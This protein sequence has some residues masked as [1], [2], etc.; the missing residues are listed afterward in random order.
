V[1]T[2]S[3]RGSKRK[4][5]SSSL[6]AT[7]SLDVLFPV[8]PFATVTQPVIGVSILKAAAIAAGFSAKVKYYNLDFARTIG[9]EFSERIT[10]FFGSLSLIG[11]WLFSEALYGNETPRA[12]HYWQLLRAEY[13]KLEDEVSYGIDFGGGRT[14]SQY[15]EQDLWP[16]LLRVRR[17]AAEAVKH[18][19]ADILAQ[20]PRVVGFTTSCHQACSTLAVAQLLK[21]HPSSPVIIF[22]GP[23][24]HEDLGLNWLGCFDWIDYVCTGEAEEVFPEFLRQLLREKRSPVIAGMLCRDNA[25]L[26]VPPPVNLDKSPTPDYHDYFQQLKT[27]RLASKIKQPVLPLETSRGCWWGENRQ[28]VFCGNTRTG[29]CY[30]S[31]PPEKALAEIELLSKQYRFSYFDTVDDAL[32]KEQ[33][34]PV[35]GELSKQGSKLRF[36]YQTRPDLTRD[37]LSTLFRGGV[38]AIQPGI[39]SLSDDVLRLMRKGT[40]GLRNIQLLRWAQEVG[41]EVS[42]RILYGFPEEPVS[43]Y[44]RMTELVPLLAHIT[45]PLGAVMIALKRFSPHWSHPDSFGLTDVR[46]SPAYFG[47]YPL[48]ETKLMGIATQFSFAYKDQRQPFEYAKP[49]RIQVGRWID[50][51]HAKPN[52]RPRLDAR[53]DKEDLFIDDTRLCAERRHHHLR[54]LA[55]K[56]YSYCDRVQTAD[57]IRHRFRGEASD[58]QIDETLTSLLAAKLLLEDRDKYLSLAIFRN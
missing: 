57:A 50:L 3:R 9:F 23:N 43:E 35:F 19:T 45:P 49:L 4:S 13:S 7:P 31:K 42:W 48:D 22:G 47:I 52:G 40:T 39:E 37:Q 2:R 21:R 46:P 30:R 10:H 24:C 53:R 36:V 17:T 28:C 33:I 12:E 8:L 16:E 14:F 56:T 44:E 25:G 27:S 51:A 34:D 38:K 41:M 6:K 1:K 54:G 58:R 20:H 29:I 26:S 15:V 11:D 5:S 55:A 18:W 32:D